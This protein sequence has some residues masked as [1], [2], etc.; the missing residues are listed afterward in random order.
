M[1]KN[2]KK[3]DNLETLTGLLHDVFDDFC[4]LESMRINIE[5]SEECLNDARAEYEKFNEEVENK[6]RVI[7]EV[8]DKCIGP[9]TKSK[10]K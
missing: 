3:V 6:L 7:R 1:A 2:Q 4:E 5:D 9:T 8:I 10:K